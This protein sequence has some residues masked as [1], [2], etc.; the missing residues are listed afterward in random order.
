MRISQAIRVQRAISF[1][2]N[3][4]SDG[5][6]VVAVGTLMKICTSGS[7]V[8]NVVQTLSAYEDLNPGAGF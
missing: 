5:H 4:R 8:I 3:L 6:K 1:A 7:L 2:L